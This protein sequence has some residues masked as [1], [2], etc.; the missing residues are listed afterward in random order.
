VVPSLLQDPDEVP[1]HLAPYW[2]WE[3]WSFHSPQWWD[4]H[5]AKTG[6]VRVDRADAI[7]DG[8]HDWL[9]FNNVSEP[10]MTGWLAEAAADTRMMLEADRGEHF[11][12]ARIVATKL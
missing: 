11:G 12:L 9:L 5:W 2:D 1:A 7:E 8:W 3:F 4:R 6:K 10:L